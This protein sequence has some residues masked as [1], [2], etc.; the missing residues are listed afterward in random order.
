ML[1]FKQE[2]KIV[3]LL[4]FLLLALSCST[5]TP[6]K[7]TKN[8]KSAYVNNLGGDHVRMCDSGKLYSLQKDK[9]SGKYKIP[10]NKRINLGVGVYQKIANTIYSCMPYLSLIP[11]EGKTYITDLYIIN[12]SCHVNLVKE[13]I[14]AE[15]GIELESTVSKGKC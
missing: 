6:Y 11:E 10:A 13:N 2:I 3:G 4:S 12:K 7:F 15:N 1:K 5:L 9:E 8:E 14:E